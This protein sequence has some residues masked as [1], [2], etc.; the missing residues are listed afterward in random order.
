MVDEIAVESETKPTQPL[1]IE[2]KRVDNSSRI[3][4][5]SNATAGTLTSVHA[6]SCNIQHNFK[7]V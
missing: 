2:D 3:A 1:F 7:N 6:I 4:V 5:R